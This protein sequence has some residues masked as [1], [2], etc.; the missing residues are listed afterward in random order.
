[1]SVEHLADRVGDLTDRH[2]FIRRAG[3]ASLAAFAG[4]MG[5]PRTAAAYDFKCCTLCRR[6]DPQ[7]PTRQYVRSCWGW[8][9]CWDN[10]H[11][12]C[13]ECYGAG[14]ACTGACTGVVC[15]YVHHP[16]SPCHSGRGGSC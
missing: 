16:P 8:N 2:A 11:T 9:C 12:H 1:M 6:P 13:Y 7:C 5:Y 3:A 15:S 14:T 10:R 4:F